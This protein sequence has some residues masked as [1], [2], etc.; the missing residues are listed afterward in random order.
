[1]LYRVWQVWRIK[2]RRLNAEERAWVRK[3]LTPA[4]HALFRVQE[5]GDQVH[6]HRV[7]VA[8]AEQ[9][10]PDEALVV[11]AL[12]HDCGKAPGVSLFHRTL[13]VLLKRVAPRLLRRI[14]PAQGG[15]LAPN[16]RAW[17]HPELGGALAEAVNCSPD[18]VA[19]IRYHQRRNPPVSPPLQAA[20][21]RLQA[22]DD[23][24]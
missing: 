17:H 5:P 3:R 16:P 14:G 20:I 22:V 2:T 4:Q 12:L 21:R 23:V 15:F 19:I 8:L 7:A 11:A 24:N 6:A 18:V 10:S 9:G 13:I 1:M